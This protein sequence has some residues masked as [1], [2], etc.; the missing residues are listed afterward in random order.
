MINPSST[1]VRLRRVRGGKAFRGR[2]ASAF[3]PLG[4]K[5]HDD[6]EGTGAIA[7][8]PPRR[9]TFL[10]GDR[11]TGGQRPPLLR[12]ARG[13]RTSCRGPHVRVDHL[14]RTPGPTRLH[15]RNRDPAL[16]A[17]R[18]AGILSNALSAGP[19]GRA[20]D[21]PSPIRGPYDRSRRP[22]VQI[23]R[24]SWRDRVENRA[25]AGVLG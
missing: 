5:A 22:G 3:R 18:A 14:G 2:V 17:D 19:F 8:D 7:D 12:L 16:R 21:P 20:T 24:A 25:A 10:S 23:G 9:P 1:K 4:W 15:R 6:V 11:R 13:A